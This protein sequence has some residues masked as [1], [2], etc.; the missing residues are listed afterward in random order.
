M[1]EK[2]EQKLFLIDGHSYCYQAFYGIK[3]LSTPDGRPINAVYGFLNMINKVL[4]EEGPSHIAV[5][6]DF[7]GPS[8]RQ[9]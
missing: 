7:K 2:P 9:L 6:F 3:E 1:S 4:K 5:V 8:F